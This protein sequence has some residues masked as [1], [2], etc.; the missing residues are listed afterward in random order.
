MLDASGD[1][2]E[3]AFANDGFVVPEFHAQRAFYDQEKF[4]F[5]VMMVPDELTFKLNGLHCAIVD[6]ADDSRIGVIREATEFFFEI[7]GFHFAPDLK[8]LHDLCYSGT[9]AAR[10][11][12]LRGF[13]VDAQKIFRSGSAHHHPP[14]FAE[15][16]FDAVHVF[17]ASDRPVKQLLQ[18]AVGEMRNSLFL[19]AGFYIEIDA[20]V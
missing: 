16:H 6:F 4:V 19:L 3:L 20:A 2:D 11:V 7:D 18:L 17:A 12:W 15:I 9:N 14:D 8:V 5:N 1:D 10:G 13:G